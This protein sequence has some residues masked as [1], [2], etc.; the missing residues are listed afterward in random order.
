MTPG[1]RIKCE[2]IGHSEP[3]KRFSWSPDGTFIA[4]PSKDGTINIWDIES[5]KSE[6]ELNNPFGKVYSVDWSPNGKYIASGGEDCLIRIW[7]VRKEKPIRILKGHSGLIFSV[8]WSFDGSVIASASTDRTVK[9]WDF[10]TGDLVKSLDEHTG[11]VLC[12]TW[13]PD[14]HILASSS[15][16]KTVRLWDAEHYQIVNVLE[17][18]SKWVLSVAWAPDGNTLASASADRTIRIWDVPSG[19]IKHVLEGHTGSIRC[20]DYSFDGHLIAS[21]TAENEVILWRTDTFEIVEHLNEPSGYYGF[22]GVNFHPSAPYLATLRDKDKIIRIWELDTGYLLKQMPS[23]FSAHYT[24]AKVVLVGDAEV[25]KTGLSLVLTGQDYKQTEVTHGRNVLLLKEEENQN[26]NGLTTKS[27]IYLWDLAGQSGYRQIHQLHLSEVSVAIVVFDANS[28]TKPFAGVSHWA[29][30]I[31]QAQ[32][33]KKKASSKIMKFL[34]S[35]RK[36]RCVIPPNRQCIEAYLT[37]YKFDEY[38]ATSAKYGLGIEELSAAIHDAIDWNSLPTVSSTKLFW[39]IKSFI[40]ETK[41]AKRLLLTIEQLFNDFLKSS[42]DTTHSTEIRS[43]FETCILHAENHGLIRRLS[44]GKLILLQPEFLDNYASSLFDAAKSEQDGLG[45]ITEEKVLS[46]DFTIPEDAR[47]K[48]EKINILPNEGKYLL[49]ATLEELLRHDIAWRETIDDE[50]IIVFPSQLTREHTMYQN[51]EEKSMVIQFEGTLHSVYST[52]VVCLWRT[53]IYHKKK[54]WKNAAVFTSNGKEECGISLNEIE[55]GHGE[56]TLFFNKKTKAK[57]RAIFEKFVLKHIKS[58][59]SQKRIKVKR[60]LKCNKCGAVIS[61]RHVEQRI[62]KHFSWIYCG[63]CENKV[64]IRVKGKGSD[65]SDTAHNIHIERMQRNAD[66]RREYEV[67]KAIFRGKTETGHFDVFLCHNSED[68]RE[69]IQIGEKLKIKGIRPWLDCWELPKSGDRTIIN[70]IERQI[71]SIDSAAIFIGKNGIGPWERFEYEAL[72]H[73]FHK[74]KCPIIPV[75]L[76]D[77]PDSPMLPPFLS[78]FNWVD[79]RKRKP[80]PMKMLIK[81]ITVKRPPT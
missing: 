35:A 54:L 13:S 42:H 12:V 3:I 47:V 51:P 20:I 31:Q 7:D 68:K 65:I 70:E 36:D 22:G 15:D 44:F 64:H 11:S 49:V 37:K 80:D 29:R 23:S 24:N 71:E 67:N 8:A 21:R 9:I 26:A 4:S 61:E 78:L 56:I 28:D 27:E 43:Q 50:T 30:A 60:M 2:L 38:F 45:F 77:A 32:K 14:R 74:R 63:V 66:E 16:D 69:I 73:Q 33:S 81:E 57:N 34:V 6:K 19:K 72:L 1:I 48:D 55:E 53:G 79:F 40:F 10:E 58:H 41:A 62:K 25:G 17:G 75:L 76:S 39:Q 59:S 18:H 5:L 46:T 52:L